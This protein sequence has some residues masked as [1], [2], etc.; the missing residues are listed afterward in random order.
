MLKQRSKP[1]RIV[2]LQREP[3]E[4]SF[5]YKDAATKNHDNSSVFL[6]PFSCQWPFSQQQY[7]AGKRSSNHEILWNGKLVLRFE[8]RDSNAHW[9]HFSTVSTFW[10]YK[11]LFI[12]DSTTIVFLTIKLRPN[13]DSHLSIVVTILCQFSSA[14][15]Y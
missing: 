15:F 13:W 4:F 14:S 1:G 11:L 7:N 6:Y 9:Y 10:I 8:W 12:P 5:P 3:P 2:C